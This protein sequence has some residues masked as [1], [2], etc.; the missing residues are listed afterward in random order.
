M[1]DY[2]GLSL[3]GGKKF[4]GLAETGIQ[5]KNINQYPL[6]L[7]EDMS[8]SRRYIDSYAQKNGV[9]LHPIIEL[10]SSDLLLSLQK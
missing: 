6:L 2:S 5:L 1:H 9:L 4:K 7:L 3:I 8:N 10:A